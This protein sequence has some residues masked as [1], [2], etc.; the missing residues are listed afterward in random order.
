MHH[1][2]SCCI[3][4]Y[5]PGIYALLPDCMGIKQAVAG[6]DY[7]NSDIPLYEYIRVPRQVC[8][9]GV[10][11]AISLKANAY[12]KYASIIFILHRHGV[13]IYQIRLKAA[14]IARTVCLLAS[15]IE[16]SKHTIVMAA[17]LMSLGCKRSVPELPLFCFQAT[18]PV[19]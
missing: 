5:L 3:T 10:V 6:S 12:C 9:L 7:H 11:L 17:H 13:P 1:Y 18:A 14:L 19:L 4:V 2:F 15:L 8:V 16:E